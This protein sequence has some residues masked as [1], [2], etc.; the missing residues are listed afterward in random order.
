MNAVVEHKSVITDMAQRFGI[1][2]AA[3]EATIKRTI[4]AGAEVSNEQMVAFLLVAKQYDLNPFVKEIYAFPARGGGIQPIVSVDG[5]LKI[6]NSHQQLDGVAFE[7]R[8]SD[9]GEP[10]AVTCKIYRKD[11]AHAT[12]VTEYMVE[13]KRDT[14]TWKKYPMRMLR[15]KALIQCARVAFSFAGIID[16]DEAERFA[17]AGAI[18]VTPAGKPVVQMPVAKSAKAEPIEGEVVVRGEPVSVDAFVAD[19]N[20]AEAAQTKREPG[21]DDA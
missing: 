1:E 16:P 20:K 10:L 5:W 14:D 13:C 17:E 15:H 12:E 3:F 2:R 4:M 11:R 6:I 19:M 18:E 21:S 7:D 9:A 8:L